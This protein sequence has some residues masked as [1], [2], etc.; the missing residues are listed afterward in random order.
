MSDDAR[1]TIVNVPLVNGDKEAIEVSLGFGGYGVEVVYLG[2]RGTRKLHIVLTADR[3]R[4]VAKALRLAAD[5]S[6]A[7]TLG[8]SR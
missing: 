8:G 2:S 7:H 5:A 3:A 4:L 1:P 6:D